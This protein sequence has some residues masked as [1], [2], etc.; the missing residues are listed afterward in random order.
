M[1][2]NVREQTVGDEMFDG[3]ILWTK[4]GQSYHKFTSDPVTAVKGRVKEWQYAL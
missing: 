1:E 2:N 4:N 3:I